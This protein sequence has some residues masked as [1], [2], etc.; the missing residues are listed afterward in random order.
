MTNGLSAEEL[1]IC[2]LMGIN[3]HQFIEGRERVMVESQNREVPLS[4]ED[5]AK[6][7]AMVGVTSEDV[8]K[9]SK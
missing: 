3:P 9:Y 8:A 2:D 5:E 7:Y 4:K 1:K 6:I